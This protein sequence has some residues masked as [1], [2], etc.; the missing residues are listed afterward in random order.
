MYMLFIYLHGYMFIFTYAF[1]LHGKLLRNDASSFYKSKS[2]LNSCKL[3]SP[4]LNSK[5]QSEL[6]FSVIT[7]RL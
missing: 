6:V 4:H 7:A 1:N 3:L 2:K 5:G